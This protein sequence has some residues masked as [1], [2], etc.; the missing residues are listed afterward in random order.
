MRIFSSEAVSERLRPCAASCHIY[1]LRWRG[2]PPRLSRHPRIIRSAWRTAWVSSRGLPMHDLGLM[3]RGLMMAQSKKSID[4]WDG[5][6]ETV[7]A[8]DSEGFYEINN[9]AELAYFNKL[10]AIK[11]CKICSDF[12]LN[13]D[14]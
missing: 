8:I 3:R 10:T 11:K 1:C 13:A 9:G 5:T 4:I 12:A 14:Y 7:P 6:T 2:Y